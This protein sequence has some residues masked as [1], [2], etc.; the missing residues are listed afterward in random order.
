MPNLGT[1]IW[2]CLGFIGVVLL[3]ES[4]TGSGAMV[5][6]GCVNFCS[7]CSMYDNFQ[8]IE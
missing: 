6:G 5:V 7:S 1:N 3:A 4:D 2:S 8:T